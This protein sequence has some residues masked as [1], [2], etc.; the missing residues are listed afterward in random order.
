MEEVLDA[1]LSFA[2]E[3]GT[4]SHWCAGVGFDGFRGGAFKLLFGIE[5]TGCE[6]NTSL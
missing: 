5:A 4:G 1:D 6:F 2:E 3:D